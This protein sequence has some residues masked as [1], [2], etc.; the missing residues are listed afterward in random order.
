MIKLRVKELADKQGLNISQLAR[1]ADV[2][3]RTIAR[4]YKDPTQ[5]TSTTVLDKIAIALNV[6]PSELISES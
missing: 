6:K 4:I 1:K 5:E 3:R 2:D